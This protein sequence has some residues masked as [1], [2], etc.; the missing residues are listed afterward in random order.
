[1]KKQIV[2]CTGLISLLG[3]N[4][5]CGNVS[6]SNLNASVNQSIEQKYAPMFDLSREQSPNLADNLKATKS[7]VDSIEI[8]AKV[9][10]AFKFGTSVIFDIG[11]GMD[12]AEVFER[13]V[14]HDVVIGR[15]KDSNGDGDGNGVFLDQDTVA[16]NRYINCR[17]QKVITDNSKFNANVGGGIAFAGLELSSRVGTGV[18]ME[19]STDYT[20]NRGFYKT[21]TPVKLARIFEL[22]AD[23][24]RSDVALQN[25]NHINEI[26]KLNFNKGEDLEKLAKQ[27]AEGKKV[28]NFKFHNMKMDFQIAKR[29]NN[30]IVFT[31]IPDTHWADPI[32]EVTVKYHREG[33][34]AVIEQVAQTC[35]K[36]CQNY[37]D[38]TNKHG[39]HSYGEKATKEQSERYI[40]LIATIFTATAL[41][42]K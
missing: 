11:G 24:G 30:R 10:A 26:V 15:E 22:C 28:N 33:D 36:D 16:G 13:K 37:H 42:S 32:L 1:M 27:V 4:A 23:I 5:A 8:G 35:K 6:D 18:K 9:S 34:R 3:L 7:T 12:F 41:N 17:S 39:L 21:K 40:K 31:V 20:M 14:L 38:E 2:M 29:E 25:I 19:A